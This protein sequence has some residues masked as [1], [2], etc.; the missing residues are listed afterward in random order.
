M[1]LVGS[2]KTVVTVIADLFLF[3]LSGGAVLV[4][5]ETSVPLA[6][7]AAIVSVTLAFFGVNNMENKRING[8]GKP[9][10]V[11]Q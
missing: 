2:R 6:G 8:N 10:E 3:V 4:L 1:N 5:K 9:E 7:I 11:K